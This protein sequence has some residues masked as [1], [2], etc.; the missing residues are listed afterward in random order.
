MNDVEKDIREITGL[1]GE[2]VA[3][4]RA[5]EG[6]NEI[7]AA[8]PRSLVQIAAGVLREPMLLLLLAGGALYLV[9]GDVEEALILLSFVFVVMGITFYQE[10]KTERA[11]EALRDLSSPRALVIRDGRQQRVAGREVVRGD[12]ILLAEGDRVPADAVVLDS[13]NLS[14]DESLLTGESVPV[15]KLAVRTGTDADL[16]PGGDDSPAVFSGTLVVKG[17][18]IAEVRAIGTATELGRIGTALGGLKP[19]RTR[20][21]REV[22]GLVRK[23]AVLGLGLCGIVVLVYGATRGDWLQ[24]TLAG[25]TLAMAMLPEEFP[26][27]LTVFLALG[28]WRI[29]QR[30]VLTRRMPAIETLGSATVLCVDKTG[31]LTQNRMTV[32]EVVT[33]GERY[34]IDGRAQ[35]PETFHEIVEYTV[36][37][38]PVDPFDPMD[39][40]FKDLGNRFLAQ[41]EHLHADWTLVREYPL[42]EHLLALSHVWRSPDGGD[43]VIAAKG[44]PEAIGD[45]CHLS[46][47]GTRQLSHRVSTMAAGG[48]RVLG[49]A[50]ASF[51][52]TEGLPPEQHDFE[53]RFLG[54]V[55]LEDPIR[56]TV[57]D[58]VRECYS[59]GIRVV[60][61]TGDYPG[62]A[63]AIA[64]QIGLTPRKEVITGPELAGMTDEQLA[65]RIDAVNVFA[66]VV[67]EQK[68]RIVRALKA[69]GEVVAMTG[70]GVNDA[71]A[72]KAA[73]IGIA[74][75]ERGTDV[76]RESAALVLTDDDFGSIVG[77]VRMG[78]RIFDNLKKAMSY[79]LAV[80][81]P[82]AGMSLLPVVFGWPIVLMPVHIAF[83]EL[84]IDPACSVVFEAE[85]E[86]PGVME[87][88]PRALKE[89]LFSARIVALALA[90][91]VAVLT[92]VL[93]VFL[94]TLNRA[95]PA[96]EHEAYVRAVTFTTLVLSNLGLIVA[97][98][99][100]TRSV[101]QV[102]R[103]GNRALWWV[104]A[105]ALAFLAAALYLPFF[106]NLFRFGVLRLGDVAVAVGAAA[107]GVLWFELLK[108][109]R[110]RRSQPVG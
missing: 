47:S 27:V 99:S 92:V 58:A 39:T 19:E 64:E 14:V 66:R 18:G 20:L 48:L 100:W 77:A 49:V 13:S 33:D 72:L 83:L 55:G 78:R 11:L 12:V 108:L 7:P 29:S 80:H 23:L 1:S 103:M 110:G 46:E 75:G 34:R 9:L 102:L 91:G 28:A 52:M 36:L 63:C 54:L 16:T 61:I 42:S 65:K 79:I 107:A 25:I 2:E 21:Q 6:P 70:D 53:F 82:I 86:E 41:T 40:A 95:H 15:R 24:G 96:P 94:L 104:L 84:I 31:T 85:R 62:T 105:G 5:E 4:R 50:A 26:V 37:A 45:L 44:A 101:F 69:V 73:D 35:L 93:A 30:H 51:R 17:Q 67:P 57:P 60:M 38:S 97:N 56:P 59:A 88:P 68:L 32:R 106:R 98:L 71:P 8:R 89:P 43:Y 3:R 81:V 90:Q 87:R 109:F 76:A 10:R 22:D 74:M